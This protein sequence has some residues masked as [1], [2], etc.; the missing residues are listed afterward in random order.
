MQA[1]KLI[2]IMKDIQR[3]TV[4]IYIL[5]QLST[6]HIFN[7]STQHNFKNTPDIPYLSEPLSTER[8][9]RNNVHNSKIKT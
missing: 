1:S 7:N 6:L 4:K 9:A 8:V 3:N 2:T 5:H